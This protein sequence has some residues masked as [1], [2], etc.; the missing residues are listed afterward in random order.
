MTD[1]KEIFDIL[2]VFQLQG[3]IKKVAPIGN[4]LIN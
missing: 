2:S 3:T 1:E 4:G